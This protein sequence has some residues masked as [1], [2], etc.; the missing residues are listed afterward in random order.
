MSHALEQVERK[1]AE[2]EWMSRRG[3][4]DQVFATPE[5]FETALAPASTA[6]AAKTEVEVNYKVDVGTRNQSARR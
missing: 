3:G 6:T 4:E 2:E 5:V 1:E